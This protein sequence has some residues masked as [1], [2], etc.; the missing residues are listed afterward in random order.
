MAIRADIDAIAA[1]DRKD[2]EY[3]SLIVPSMIANKQL[4][5]FV[6]HIGADVLGENQVEEIPKPSMGGEDFAFYSQQLPAAFIRLGC[7][8]S[9]IGNLP[10][11]NSGFDIDERVLE[12]GVNMM[13]NSAISYLI[14]PIL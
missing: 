12:V 8:G 2:V 11:H 1:N 7:H 5:D 9:G 4:T 14:N 6:R 3:R 10:L 13:A